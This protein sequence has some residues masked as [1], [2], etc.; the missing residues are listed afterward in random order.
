MTNELQQVL[1]E[2]FP[3]HEIIRTDYLKAYDG[4][5]WPQWHCRCGGNGYVPTTVYTSLEQAQKECR[6]EGIS[7]AINGNKAEAMKARTN[8]AFSF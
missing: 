6:A 8:G 3:V 5:L 4:S 7:H 1:V 2:T